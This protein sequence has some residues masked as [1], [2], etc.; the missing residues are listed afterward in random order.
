MKKMKML[1]KEMLK[2]RRRCYLIRQAN[3][4]KRNR[5]R[6][7]RKN[8]KLV[9]KALITDGYFSVDFNFSNSATWESRR[10]QKQIVGYSILQGFNY[11]KSQK[12]YKFYIG[13][14]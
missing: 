1:N 7:F 2:F 12:E 6:R 4:M 3:R 9:K 5:Y 14:N 8:L 13:D 11:R 10:C